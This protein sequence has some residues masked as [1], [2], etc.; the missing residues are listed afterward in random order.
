MDVLGSDYVYLSDECSQEFF[1]LWSDEWSV[2]DPVNMPVLN[3]DDDF[4]NDVMFQTSESQDDLLSDGALESVC[5]N[6]IAGHVPPQIVTPSTGSGEDCE[7]VLSPTDSGHHSIA[8]STTEV[9][10]C[11]GTHVVGDNQTVVDHVPDTSDLSNELNNNNCDINVD[12]ASTADSVDCQVQEVDDECSVV[13]TESAYEAMLCRPQR[14]AARRAE[15][16]VADEGSSDCDDDDDYDVD[17]LE[18]SRVR[19][20]HQLQTAKITSSHRGRSRAAEVNR[21]AVNARINRQKKKAYMASLEAQKARLLDENKRMKSALTSMMS[22]RNDLV[23]EVKYLKS[24]LANDSA[25]AHLVQ[26]INGPPLKLSS[27]FDSVAQKRKYVETDH[28]YGPQG[29][30]RASLGAGVKE[31]GICLHVS[32]NHLSIELCHRCASMSD[33][34][35]TGRDS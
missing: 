35:S 27:R 9:R 11:T 16:A 25:L 21:N 34:C 1:R 5:P 13:E 17:E 15:I 24:V 31:G 14:L 10:C 19:S 26:S 32:E 29:K 20:R 2:G 12:P 6:T 28:S 18:D 3:Y 23:D 30:R 4:L 22:Q 7:D 8:S 33:G